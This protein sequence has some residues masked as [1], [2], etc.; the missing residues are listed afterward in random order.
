M[1]ASGSD[2]K[3]QNKFVRAVMYILVFSY[4]F[5]IKTALEAWHCIDNGEKHW[6]LAA[7]PG[8]DC[9]NFDGPWSGMF[10]GSFFLYLFYF[11]FVN[12][13]FLVI[14]EGVNE[15]DKDQQH[16]YGFIF[17]KYKKD[18]NL[19]E[20]LLNVKKTFLVLFAVFLSEYGTAQTA[21]ALAIILIH[22]AAQLTCKPYHEETNKKEGQYG[23]PGTNLFENQI[24]ALES[25]FLF[26][27]LL[28]HT[29]VIEKAA[30]TVILLTITF[31]SVALILH[32]VLP[33][34]LD[35]ILKSWIYNRLFCCRPPPEKEDD[36]F[37]EPPS[38]GKLAFTCLR[39]AHKPKQSAEEEEEESSSR[40][41]SE[42]QGS[43][44]M[45]RNPEEEARLKAEADAAAAAAA[46]AAAEAEEDVRLM[47]EAEAV[48]VVVV[49]AEEEA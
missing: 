18:Y 47:A 12:M 11:F 38:W 8:I 43:N 45:R 44:P 17:G 33:G 6:Q 19:W 42:F 49:K 26:F 13:F 7:Y 28:Y 34:I 24:L 1:C 20:I 3:K 4:M 41:S 15:T 22:L 9:K 21:T 27:E 46:A 25:L 48:V 16:R 10:A 14:L 23:E 39:I 36:N 40:R 5:S 31:V 35:D 2:D 32:N 29:D 30:A 37:F